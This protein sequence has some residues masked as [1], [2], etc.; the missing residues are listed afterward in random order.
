MEET[1][2]LSSLQNFGFMICTIA[3]LLFLA[4]GA[5]ED[6]IE[7]DIDKDEGDIPTFMEQAESAATLSENLEIY[8]MMLKDLSN[9]PNVAVERMLTFNEMLYPR[10]RS[11]SADDIKG[12]DLASDKRLQEVFDRALSQINLDEEELV[13]DGRSSRMSEISQ[14]SWDKVNY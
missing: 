6:Q 13:I 2:V 12:L 7:I 10:R 4:N 3:T 5:S 11:Y 8:S 1:A 14:C 9:A